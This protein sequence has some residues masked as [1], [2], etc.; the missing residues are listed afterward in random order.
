MHA[1]IISAFDPTPVDNTRPMRFMGLADALLVRGHTVTYF[2]NTFRHATREMR[3]KG[4]T[5]KQVSEGYRL[6]FVHGIPYRGN[7]SVKRLLSHRRFGLNLL[8]EAGRQERPDVIFISIPPLTPARRITSWA[9]GQRIPVVVDIIDPWP[10]AFFRRVK[11]FRAPLY[12]IM[13]FPLSLKLRGILAG[14]SG[15]TA[16]SR[17]YLDWA[18]QRVPGPG[19]NSLPGGVFYPAVRFS[20]IR[21]RLSAL[22]AVPGNGQGTGEETLGLIYAGSLESSYDIPAITGAAEIL[23]TRYPGRTR[24]VIAGKGSQE[25]LVRSAG[26]RLANLEY[27]GRVGQEELLSLFSRCQV[28]L[29]QHRPG[30]T[31][32]VTYKLFDY[33]GAGLAVINSLQSEM[34]EIIRD[35]G[36]GMNHEPGNP[37]ALAGCVER[38]LDDPGLLGQCRSKALE[39]T[40]ARGDAPVVYGELARFLERVAIGNGD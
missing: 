19:R 6:V 21:E 23:E 40:A 2:S 34:V 9:A 30:A 18:R 15:V 10:D 14:I 20:E 37:E 11:G 24:F 39:L 36:V 27:A 35:H 3:F 38:F 8:K 31:Q 33:L 7:L 32:T 4:R 25:S 1:W 12:R 26:Q 29:I 13:V 22:G 16:I 5:V 17:E 28:G